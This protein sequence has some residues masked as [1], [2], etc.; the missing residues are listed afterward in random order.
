MTDARYPERWLNDRRF[1]RLPDG[2][3]RLFFIS[4]A[5]AV[6]NRTDGVIYDDDLALMPGIDAG[7]AKT[8]AK[9]DLW[10]RVSDH[11]L[12]LDYEE[13]QTSRSDLEVLA[14][15]RKKAREKKRRQRAAQRD[16]PGDDLVLSPGTDE[17]TALGQDRPGQDRRTR[18]EPSAPSVWPDSRSY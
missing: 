5:W 3:F 14:H 8:L 9:A 17:G 2:A 10:E 15:A 18:A 13:T 6:A 4:L 12:I 1:L 7:Q 11:W 16:V